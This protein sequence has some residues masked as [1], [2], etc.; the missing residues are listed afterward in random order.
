[1]LGC[2]RQ[3]CTPSSNGT[4]GLGLATE[5]ALQHVPAGTPAPPQ[6]A[7]RGVGPAFLAEQ[8]RV[9][10][11]GFSPGESPHRRFAGAQKC[12]GVASCVHDCH[13]SLSIALR[14]CKMMKSK[15]LINS[16][17]NLN[18]GSG[19]PRGLCDQIP[20]WQLLLHSAKH[21]KSTQPSARLS[22]GRSIF[23]AG[24]TQRFSPLMNSTCAELAVFSKQ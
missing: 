19:I 3:S 17:E 16:T 1:M 8:S 9:E 2:R 15:F 21:C 7:G 5:G 14:L 4:E 24:S 11:Y 6:S 18:Q 12:A 10:G 20:L 13:G 23:P 22:P